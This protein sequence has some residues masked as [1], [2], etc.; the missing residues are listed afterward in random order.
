MHRSNE[1]MPWWRRKKDKPLVEHLNLEDN[2]GA[3]RWSKWREW[4]NRRRRTRLTPPVENRNLA[5]TA[6]WPTPRALEMFGYAND[7]Q[8]FMDMM[9]SKGSES[10]EFEAHLRDLINKVKRD[11]AVITMNHRDRFKSEED[12]I[13]QIALNHIQD[14]EYALNVKQGLKNQVANPGTTFWQAFTP[15]EE[16]VHRPTLNTGK[17]EFETA[18][19][20]NPVAWGLGPMGPRLGQNRFLAPE[21]DPAE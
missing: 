5:A 21:E 14:L 7:E 15:E 11:Y 13:R 9:A 10:E 1:T 8:G 17:P 4:W 3:S 16:P 2:S 12:A 20:Y 19:P 18:S 6:Q